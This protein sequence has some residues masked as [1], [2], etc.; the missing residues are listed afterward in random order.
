[1]AWSTSDRKSRLP[2]DWP[3]RRRAVLERCGGRCE[4]LRKDGSRCRD[5]ATDVDH[6]N[7]GD[8]HGLHNLR[9]ICSWHHARKSAREGVE[10]RRELNSIL[11]RK[12]ETH[13]GIIPASQAKPTPNR[14]F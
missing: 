5:K 13:P 3:A 11:Y 12:P 2:A 14:G 4:V 1:M 7:P 6:V 9:G 10:A 8:D